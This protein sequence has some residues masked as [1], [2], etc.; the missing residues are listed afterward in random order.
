MCTRLAELAQKAK[1]GNGLDEGVEFGPINNKMQ[2]DRVKELLSDAIANGAKGVSCSG[3]QT[4]TAEKSM[5][6]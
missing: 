5:R 1:V 6:L 2:Y 3:N 4:L